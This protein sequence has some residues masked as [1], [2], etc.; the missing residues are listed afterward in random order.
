MFLDIW[1]EYL[2]RWEYKTYKIDLQ[3]DR[4]SLLLCILDQSVSA[5]G[6]GSMKAKNK[7]MLGN[8]T[9]AQLSLLFGGMYV[10]LHHYFNKKKILHCEKV[11]KK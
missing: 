5:S 7:F 1:L 10:Y 2:G 9:L 8:E 3:L 11:R 4:F 6:L